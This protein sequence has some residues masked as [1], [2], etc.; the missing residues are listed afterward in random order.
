MSPQA[1]LQFRSEILL[2]SLEITCT[3]AVVA[4]YPKLEISAE[5]E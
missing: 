3:P 5:K 1:K 2:V 4:G